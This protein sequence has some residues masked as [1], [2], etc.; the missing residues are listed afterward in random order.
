SRW[1]AETPA[2]SS[3]ANATKTG[4]STTPQDKDSSTCAPFATRSRAGFATSSPNSPDLLK[5]SRRQ[6]H[7]L[8]GTRAEPHACS[9]DAVEDHDDLGDLVHQH[10]RGQAEYPEQRQREQHDDDR[11]GEGDVAG[12]DR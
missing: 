7:G 3:P 2:R 10:D 12:H 8:R 1:D 5:R 4:S 11:Q 6:P 9:A